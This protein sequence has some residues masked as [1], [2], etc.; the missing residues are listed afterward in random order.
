[1]SMNQLIPIVNKLQDVFH[2]VGMLDTIDLPQIAVVGSQSSGKSSVLE[3]IVGKDFLP[4]GTGIVTRRPLVLQ[5]IHTN[6][7]EEYGEFLHLPKRKISDFEEIRNE[8]QAETERVTGKE[9]KSISAL[10]IH[11]K[12]H[13]P[14]VLNLT[15]IDLPGITKVPVG[16][17]PKDIEYQIKQMILQYIKKP[18]CIILAVS[19]ANT[20]IAN[21]EALKLARAVDKSGDRTVGVLTK[22]DLMDKGTDAMDV[23]NGKHVPLKLG[24]VGVV[25]RGQQDIES[26]KPIKDALENEAEFFKNHPAYRSVANRMG[27]AFL[28]K[29]L[30]GILLEHIRKCLPEIRSKIS[31]LISKAQQRLSEYGVPLEESEMNHGAMLLQLLTQFSKEFGDVIEGTNVDLTT[32]ELFGGARI[33]HIFT[34]KFYPMLEKMDACEGLTDYDIRT[35]IRNAKGPRTSLFIPEASFVMLVKKQVKKLEDPSLRCV[36]QVFE[37]LVAIVDH[38]EKHLVRFPKLRERT[39]E[40]VADLLRRYETPLKVFI[41]NLI[42]I[43]LAYINTNHPDFFDGGNSSFMI[44]SQQFQTNVNGQKQQQGPP[45][46]QRR[47][48]PSQQAGAPQEVGIFFDFGWRNC[49]LWEV[50]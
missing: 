18:N 11:L 17:Q 1:M 48:N 30:N 21:S 28:T 25:L 43:E 35:A 22:L 6:E 10:P 8:I 5:L 44:M 49:G 46:P 33:N 7:G 26:N 14:H 29:K 45:V 16:N 47:S 42:Q 15:L 9:G 2:S 50:T 23:I 32:D 3:N 19:P 36:N 40:F 4:R 12:I 31:A 24:F 38:A 20:D 39:K 34:E 13:S 37:E 27:I 41:K